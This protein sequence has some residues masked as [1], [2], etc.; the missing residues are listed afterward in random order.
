MRYQRWITLGGLA[1]AFSGCATLPHNNVL[2]FGTDTKVAL[3]ISTSATSGGAPQITL[4][5]RR[6]EATWMPLVVNKQSCDG[7]GCSVETLEIESGKADTIKYQGKK[8]TTIFEDGDRTK[9]KSEVVVEDSYS[10]FASFGA[11]FSGEGN[12]TSVQGSGGLAQFF[13][14]GIA[15]QKLAENDGVEDVLKV[16]TPSERELKSAQEGAEQA[17]N[18]LA[19]IASAEA[20]ARGVINKS[21][22]ECLTR[23]EATR[24]KFHDDLPDSIKTPDEAKDFSLE[25]INALAD[26]DSV[27]RWMKGLIRDER[28]TVEM[29]VRTKT[30][31]PTEA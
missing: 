10:V 8:T 24:E 21:V 7:S 25:R 19:E 12:S 16:S 31:S 1:I 26:E 9:P 18:A 30:C 11:K 29:T 2:L 23:G 28:V 5:Y 14:T 13:A 6:A 22:A 4:G 15:A 17:N 20:E 27:R 3:D